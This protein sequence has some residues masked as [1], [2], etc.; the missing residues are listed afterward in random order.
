MKAFINRYYRAV[1]YKTSVQPDEV[2]GGT[3]MLRRHYVWL[4][5]TPT[6][7]EYPS[8][9]RGKANGTSATMVPLDLQMKEQL[10]I[11]PNRPK[12]GWQTNMTNMCRKCTMSVLLERSSRRFS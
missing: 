8:K 12:T 6:R 5:K 7:T 1:T 3:L 10:N 2:N 4:L 9:R 11:E